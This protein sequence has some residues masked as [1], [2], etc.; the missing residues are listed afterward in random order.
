ME[1]HRYEQF[2]FALSLLLIVG[3]IGTITFGAVGAGVQMISD[4]GGT[5]EP[6]FQDINEHEKFAQQDGNQAVHV[7]DDHYEVAVRAQQFG[8]F[9]GTGQPIEVPEGSTVTFY[10]TSPDVIHG[11]DI[12][13]TNVNTMVIPG[14]IAEFTVEFDELDGS[15][16]EEYGIVCNEFCGAGHEDMAGQL[17]VIPSDEWDGD[18]S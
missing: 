8:F 2:W 11:L 13:G 1:I 18:Q 12:I 7:E 15:D 16:R 6:T 14:Q 5:V 10:V 3:F 17:H 4:D 9:P